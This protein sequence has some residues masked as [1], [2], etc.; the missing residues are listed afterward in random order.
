MQ[1]QFQS[2]WNFFLNYRIQKVVE[3]K[4]PLFSVAV[5]M[6]VVVVPAKGADITKDWNK[7]RIIGLF[8]EINN[9]FYWLGSYCEIESDSCNIWIHTTYFVSASLVFWIK[10]CFGCLR[11]ESCILSRF[12]PTFQINWNNRKK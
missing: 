5:V 9:D 6:A 8:Y 3:K 4:L 11:D 12:C 10:G 2:G 1:L 7:N